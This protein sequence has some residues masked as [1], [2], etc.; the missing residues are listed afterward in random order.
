[1]CD[2]TVMCLLLILNKITDINYLKC[3]RYTYNYEINEKMRKTHYKSQRVKE[4]QRHDTE[5][6]SKTFPKL[7]RKKVILN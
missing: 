2:L 3:V 5:D 4:A 6:F 7:S 1:M